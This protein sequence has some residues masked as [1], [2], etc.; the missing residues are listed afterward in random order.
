MAP[1]TK[2]STQ[3]MSAEEQALRRQEDE[4]LGRAAWVSSSRNGTNLPART[5]ADL[6]ALGAQ[7][8]AGLIEGAKASDAAVRTAAD[9]ATFG[10][11]A[12]MSAGANALLGGGGEGTLAQRYSRLLAAEEAVDG[13]NRE[14]R[15][16]ATAAGEIGMTALTF[17][18]AARAGAKAVSQATP[19]TKGKIGE[20]MSEA[21]TLLSGEIPINHGKRY[22]LE[23]PGH[24][25]TDHQTARGLIVEAKL[26][27]S[28]R[29]TLRQRQ[30]QAELGSRY[31]KDHWSFDDVG[32]VV[33][34]AAVGVQQGIGRLSETVQD[35]VYGRHRR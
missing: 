15:P 6:R 30:A 17:R 32:R 5:T 10:L 31:R 14:H 7:V 20:R 35:A 22:E 19:R 27:P 2:K 21:R 4:E 25:F 18:G 24:T 23:G 8:R 13:R 11:A 34:G 9:T 3:G 29:M 12:E 16:L 28:A 26:G 33:G 1:Y